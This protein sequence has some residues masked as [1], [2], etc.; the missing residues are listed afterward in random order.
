MER[1]T[2]RRRVLLI[3]DE[4]NLLVAITDG[5]TL[6]GGYEVLVASDGVTG[7]ERFF[8]VRPDCVVVDVRMPG[9]NGYQFV[10]ALR[11]DPETMETPII[12]LSALVQD[13]EQLA[14]LLTGA[15]A[16]LTKPVKIS[17][18]VQTIDTALRLTAQERRRH[19]HQ[20]FE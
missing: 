14:G 10:R 20:L 8:E 18:L 1:E 6:M 19:A 5:L 2:V 13:Q 11:G 3:D 7:L 16:Y 12:V 9:L 4:P 17:T 15:D